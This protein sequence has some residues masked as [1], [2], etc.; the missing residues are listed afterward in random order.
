MRTA[1]VIVYL[2]GAVCTAWCLN[3]S[4][5]NRDGRSFL[6]ISSLFWPFTATVFGLLVLVALMAHWYDKLARVITGGKVDTEDRVP[7]HLPRPNV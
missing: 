3:A 5:A 4:S 1:V 2:A 7:S 6:S